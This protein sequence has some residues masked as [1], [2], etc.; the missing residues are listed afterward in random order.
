MQSAPQVHN[1]NTLFRSYR[2][3]NN[4]R[5]ND[6][7]M[8]RRIVESYEKDDSAIPFHGY[9]FSQCDIGFKHAL[10]A[11]SEQ[12]KNTR[13][14][15][16]DKSNI[17]TIATDKLTHMFTALQGTQIYHVSLKEVQ[18]L[19]DKSI[20]DLEAISKAIF[21]NTDVYLVSVEA[22]FPEDKYRALVKHRAENVIEVSMEQWQ[23]I[24]LNEQ[25]KRHIN[26]TVK[27]DGKKAVVI[28][29]ENNA[30]AIEEF[31]TMLQQTG[32]ESEAPRLG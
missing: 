7:D 29:L 31:Q 21:K 18:G 25:R 22:D 5:V 12:D 16:F 6:C 24:Q 4:I 2:Y 14:I 13:E 11:I 23:H 3:L 19:A 28:V 10:L 9:D 27:H 30:Q 15:Y 20:E 32:T 26:R 8:F 1:P 17:G